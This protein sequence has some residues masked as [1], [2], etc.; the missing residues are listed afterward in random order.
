MNPFF[1][2][3]PEKPTQSFDKYSLL[4]SITNALTTCNTN[5]NSRIS[6]VFGKSF[7]L[8]YVMNLI[9][10]AHSPLNNINRYSPEHKDGDENGKL[11]KISYN[12]NNFNG[13]R[14]LM[15]VKAT[16]SNLFDFWGNSMGMF[17][18]I[19]FPLT[20]LTEV[21]KFA[22]DLMKEFPR[23]AFA[24]ELKDISK[25]SWSDKST[26]LAKDFA[27]KVK[28]GTTVTSDY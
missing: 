23:S 22:D 27:Y 9:G 16:S 2:G 5:S 4:D 3:V 25:K 1:D 15:D 26:Q 7:Q 21:N 28:E 18:K 11:H 6:D 17:G 13:V 20:K 8:R 19:A 10:E 12:A 14:E 24:T